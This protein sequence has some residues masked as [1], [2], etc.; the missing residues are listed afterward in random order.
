M[1]SLNLYECPTIPPY[2]YVLSPTGQE[3]I[4]FNTENEAIR[5][6]CFVVH[7]FELLELF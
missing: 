2:Y 1:I 4:N 7:Y 3:Q 6:L 5:L